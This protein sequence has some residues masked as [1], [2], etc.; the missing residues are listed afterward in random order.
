MNN[1]EKLL[2]PMFKRLG[3]NIHDKNLFDKTIEYY[4]QLAKESSF[5][6]IEA[7]LDR[8]DSIIFRRF[9]VFAYLCK[10]SGIQKV[11]IDLER[12]TNVFCDLIFKIVEST[13]KYDPTI[14]N[15]LS[16]DN[17]LAHEIQY[18]KY[19]TMIMCK[20]YDL[21][22]IDFFLF[23]YAK[24][25]E[26]AASEDSWLF[27]TANFLVKFLAQNDRIE[28]SLY[29]EKELS[30]RQRGLVE[31]NNIFS[32]PVKK[33]P[34]SSLELLRLQA[35][36]FWIEYLNEETWKFLSSMSKS[37]LIDSFVTEHLLKYAV[38]RQWSQLVLSL[39]KVVEREMAQV[40]F[41]PWINIIRQ[42]RF[43][44]P[45]GISKSKT[46]RVISRKYTFETLMKCATDSVHPPTLGQLIFV[47]RFWEDPIMDE[48]TDLFKDIRSKLW[49]TSPDYGRKIK[50][51]LK[52]LEDRNVINGERPNINE[53]RNASA[54]P[55]KEKEYDWNQ[56]SVWLKTALG[57]PPKKIL[58]L[59]VVDLRTIS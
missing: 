7:E 19:A 53:L 39:C 14:Q 18:S 49:T 15:I 20:I 42:S 23:H 45:D 22:G 40:L 34:K 33:S 6:I 56:H 25:E 13:K 43:E 1:S 27:S 57:E 35:E 52:Y 29:V 59:I 47:A 55:G 16:Y 9:L 11:D 48:C 58:H 38:L 28:E 4:R 31:I 32:S 3:L 30:Q 54:H 26:I 37:D 2:T 51:L 8:N 10:I 46:K 17:M 36:R 44:V 21:R 5:E 24:G 41:S 50:T 12:W